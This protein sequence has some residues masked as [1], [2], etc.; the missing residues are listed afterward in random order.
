M[1]N[2]NVPLRQIFIRKGEQNM[3]KMVMACM[4][5]VCGKQMDEKASRYAIRLGVGNWNNDEVQQTNEKDLCRECYDTVRD[6]LKYDQAEKPSV[7]K[8]AKVTKSDDNVNKITKRR[9]KYDMKKLEQMFCDGYSNQRIEKELGIPDRGAG[10]YVSLLKQKGL[11][12]GQNRLPEY[13]ETPVQMRTVV[14]GSGFV[15]NVK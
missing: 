6:L 1:R 8:R 9:S 7:D 2:S 5:D 11:T 10:Y 12:R 3:K 15:V 4:C 13:R 14:D